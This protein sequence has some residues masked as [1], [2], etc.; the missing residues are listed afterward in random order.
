MHAKHCR[1]IYQPNISNSEKSHYSKVY[2]VNRCSILLSLQEFDVTQNLPQD[3][4]HVLLE[5]VFPFHMEQLL[6][7]LLKVQVF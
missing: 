7:S 4:M 5:G 2:G 6:K 1:L 3:L